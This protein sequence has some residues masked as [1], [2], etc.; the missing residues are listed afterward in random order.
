M[1][2]TEQ[3]GIFAQL[4]LGLAG[5]SGIALVLAHRG[6]P[7]T[8]LESSRLGIM[9][10]TSLGSTFLAIL[11]LVMPGSDTEAACRVASGVM[12]TYTIALTWYYTSATSRM[13][14]QAPE[15]VT[16]R[17]RGLVV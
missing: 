8:Q 15:L 5:F 9:L 12:A 1:L 16:Q 4:G 14:R 17:A 3:L 7:L 2:G 10:G 13:R 11:P 6:S